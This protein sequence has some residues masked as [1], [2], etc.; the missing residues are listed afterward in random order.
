VAA[1]RS[2][3]DLQMAVLKLSPGKKR[4]NRSVFTR[5]SGSKASGGSGKSIDT[6]IDWEALRKEIE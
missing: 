6:G 4:E 1:L 2:L 3:L 5:D